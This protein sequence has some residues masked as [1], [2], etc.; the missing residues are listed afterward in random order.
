MEVGNLNLT[1]VQSSKRAIVGNN[2]RLHFKQRNIVKVVS[3]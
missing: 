3:L 2:V 1:G